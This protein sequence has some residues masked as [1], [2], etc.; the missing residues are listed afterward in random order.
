MKSIKILLIGAALLSVAAL[1]VSAK[2]QAGNEVKALQNNLREIAKLAS[3]AVV[4]ITTERKVKVGN[5]N[6]N[7]FGFDFG[8]P[9]LKKYFKRYDKDS[10]D[11]DNEGSRNNNERK[12]GGIGSGMIVTED[13]FI[14]TNY[15]V[16]ED[17][18]SVK[19]I[20]TN[21]KKYD[22]EV[23]GYDVRH[24]MAVLKIKSSDKFP[25]VELGDSDKLMVGDIV[26]AVGNPF[27]Y[28]NTVT[29]G[30]V[31][32]KGRLFDNMDIEGIP[33]R[34]PHVI[35]TDAPINPGNS[36]G[37]LFNIEGEVVGVNMAIAGNFSMG[38][39]GNMGVGFAIPI[40]DVKVKL[41]ELKEGRKNKDETPWVGVRLQE[42][43]E[44]LSKKLKVDSGVLITEVDE[45]G[46][47]KEA[48]LK[49]GDVILQFDGKEVKSPKNIIE[50]VASREVGEV[51]IFKI[52]RDGKEKE[53]KIILA[54]WGEKSLTVKNGNSEDKE[55]KNKDVGITVKNLSELLAKKF[56]IKADKGVVIAAVE[57]NSPADKSE[58]QVGD[59]IKEVDKKVI[60]D[61][62][63]FE[64]TMNTS[65]LKEGILFLVE[66]SGNSIFVVIS[67][68]K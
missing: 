49:S 48:G 65:D 12:M 27:G 46:P 5:G 66:R 2:I 58:L 18:T 57:K 35:Q 15:H 19:V 24:D 37:P 67:S 41:K 40:N 68:E 9:D 4:Y 47:G 63:D 32:A 34:I 60:K 56:G 36:G 30:I 3:P 26:I 33:K 10:E 61:R 11:E 16:V 1:P 51:V 42:V 6:D 21:D 38:S 50:M 20:L 54:P 62:D 8:M 14:L 17:A 25:A 13:G 7:G 43:D 44:K 55:R 28:E 64:K 52:V 59:L 22:A 29:M 45:N 23:K 39:V 31:S 53:I